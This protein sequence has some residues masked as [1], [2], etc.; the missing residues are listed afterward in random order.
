MI[1][2]ETPQD[3]RSVH[4]Q[5]GSVGFLKNVLFVFVEG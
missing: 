4:A 2:D 1:Q 5:V 3:G